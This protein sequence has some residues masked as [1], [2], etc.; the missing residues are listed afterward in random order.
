MLVRAKSVF[1]RLG[2]LLPVVLCQLPLALIVFVVALTGPLLGPGMLSNSTFQ[3]GLGLLAVLT[4][5][6][7]FL[8]WSRLPTHAS[9]LIPLLD[10]VAI[11]LC[12]EGATGL[13][14]DFGVLAIFPVAW[15]AASSS[16]W[17][18]ALLISFLG[19][20][21][22][23]LWPFLGGGPTSAA[24][25]LS[26]LLLPVVMVAVVLAV[27][28]TKGQTRA[29]ETEL[30]AKDRKVQELL[31]A[32]EERE[33]LL[34]T[35]LET[36]DVGLIAVDSNGH[37]T[38]TNRQ[39][40]LFHRLAGKS[41]DS[42]PAEE[43]QKLFQKD[44][45]TP[46]PA[47]RRPVHRALAGETFSNHLV[48]IGSGPEQRVISAAGRPMHNDAGELTGSV[49]ICSDVTELVEAVASKDA[50][51][52]NVSHDFHAPLTS[53]LGYLELVLEDKQLP[54]HLASYIDVAGRNADRVLHLVAD[55][56][57]TAG[58]SVRVHPRPT[59]LAGLIEMSVRSSQ[60]SAT[61]AGVSFEVD[62]P[63]PTWS[64]LDPLRISQVLDNL[65]SNAIK[66]SPSGG[67]V[68]VSVAELPDALHLR[69][70]DT[71]MGMAQHETD[72]VFSRFYR[73]EAARKTSIPGVGLGLC[74]TKAIVEGHGGSIHCSSSP[75]EGTTFTV[76]LP[77][78]GNVA[79]VPGRH[80]ADHA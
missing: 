10:F 36:V 37:S 41:G 21:L 19:S 70:R 62:V 9:L 24:E 50:F 33:R 23:V 7:T 79:P 75:G 8:P 16:R 56:L 49:I 39:Q 63:S 59:D 64:L 57:T 76:V 14:P 52:S 78:N 45:V 25:L 74:V 47:N 71:G 13:Q 46:L 42:L 1:G 15:V 12:R 18:V 4:A 80:Y 54:A 34:T 5:L 2:I 31:Q 73:T 69:V 22:L 38:L 6:S 55:L 48:W 30:I 27:R 11:A 60:P 44:G 26:T 61:S 58:D 77:V 43:E 53:I 28:F 32:S 40:E 66:Y 17:W 3:C 65:L 68:A 67:T 20:F 35:I 51:I 29:H 72:L